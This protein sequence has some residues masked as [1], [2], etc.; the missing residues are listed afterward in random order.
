MPHKRNPSGC[1]VVLSAATRM[2]GLV[3]TMLASG[4]HE[5]E[6]SV[7]GWH[8]EG[9]VVADAIQTTGSA[10][11][12]MADV[13]DGLAVDIARMRQNIDATRGVVFA[14]RVTM[15]IAPKVG[16]TR[17]AELVRNAVAAAR[18]SGATLT[19]AVAAIPELA[20]LLSAADVAGLAVPETYL[21]SPTGS[22]SGCSQGPANTPSSGKR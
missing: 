14:E 11:S 13:I 12:A 1:A 15:T 19:E 9:P 20:S 6:R 17:A 16:R 8:A 22:V 3:A 4:A 7:G 18:Q 10:L 2:P 5:H 21:G